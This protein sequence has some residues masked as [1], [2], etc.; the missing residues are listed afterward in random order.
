MVEMRLTAKGFTTT[1]GF[2]RAT[3]SLHMTPDPLHSFDYYLPIAFQF[4]AE[5]CTGSTFNCTSGIKG[6]AG[7]DVTDFIFYMLP[8]RDYTLNMGAA[9]EQRQPDRYSISVGGAGTLRNG[10]AHAFVDPLISVAPTS[11]GFTV[12]SNGPPM[13]VVSGVPE[14][15]SW[16]MLIAGFGLVGAVARRRRAIPRVAG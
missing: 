14:P 12:T 2:Y 16:A 9:V 1:S 13:Q 15:D 8:N 7:W 6:P 11:S 3:A 5:S 10:T 4:Y